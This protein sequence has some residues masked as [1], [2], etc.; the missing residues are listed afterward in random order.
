MADARTNEEQQMTNGKERLFSDFTYSTYEQWRSAVEKTLKGAPFEKRLITKT[1]EGIDLQPM[2]RQDDIAHLTYTYTLPGAVP[3][4]RGTSAAGYVGKPWEIAQEIAASTPAAFNQALH[5]D[6]ERGQTAVNLVLDQA[7][8]AGLDPDQAQVGQVG[9]DGVSIANG[10]DLAQ[11]L[12]GVDLAQVPVFI[13]AGATGMPIAALL[14]AVLQRQGQ[15]LANLR[16]AIT[17]DPLGV[18][19]EQGTLPVGLEQAYDE[20]AQLTQWAIAQAPHL[21]TIGI[22]GSPYHN[23]GGS[24]VQELAFVLATAVTYLREMQERGIEVDEAAPRMR[25]TFSIG[26]NFFMETARLRAARLLWSQIVSAFGG[27]EEAQ[28]M[29]IH[30]RTGTW[31]KT[32]LDPYVNML[33]TTLESFAGAVGGCDS[34]H[35]APF[36]EVIRE[37]DEFSRRIARNTHIILQKECN[38]AQLIDPAGGSWYIESLTDQVASKAWAL[39]QEVEKQGGI[40]AALQAGFPQSEVAK[41]AA[42][43][44]KGLATR[45]DVLVGT[46]MYANM[47]EKPLEARTP[48]YA[49]L[50]KARA[51][52]VKHTDAARYKLAEIATASYE[53][54][55]QV[56]ID[57]ALAGATLGELTQAL[58]SESSTPSTITPVKLHRGAEQYEALRM[59]AAHQKESTGRAPQV[60][61]ATMGTIAQ[62]KGRADFATGFFEVGGFE[63]IPNKG[64]ATPEEAVKAALASGAPIVVIC[65]TDET[66]PELVPP[67]TQ[68]LKAA[69]SNLRVILAGYPADQV[70]AHKAA[71]VD[72]FIH[73]RANCYEI[74]SRLQ[75]QIGVKA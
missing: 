57:A 52:Q 11:A 42:E 29:T 73:I 45:K 36:D 43:R 27:S 62:Y 56:L 23:S 28:K 9:K 46:N 16:G 2:Y 47:K 38:L 44:A 65:S 33:R 66:Y 70:E 71:G 54:A 6:M 50:H 35:I 63:V 14:A 64:F 49:A 72:D 34:M 32:V 41:T 58:R 68:Q 30:A 15:S 22:Q 19:A 20:L 75:Q 17:T 55:P 26:A 39:F 53:D 24:A 69:N 31:N 40:A 12:N 60:F 5:Y 18:L 1:Y 13:Y 7:A 10:D 21:Q 25:F 51:S 67:I 59:A 61:L 8:R 48:D 4:V 3:F 74:L 37:S